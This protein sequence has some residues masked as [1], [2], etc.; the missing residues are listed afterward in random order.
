MKLYLK[1][2]WDIFMGLEMMV[3]VNHKFK[4]RPTGKNVVI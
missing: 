3:K 1:R 2:N 4:H